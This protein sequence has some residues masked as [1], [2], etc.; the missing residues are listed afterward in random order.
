MKIDSGNT[1]N[2]GHAWL[3]ADAVMLQEV[4]LGGN[5]VTEGAIAKLRKELP[6]CD[7]Y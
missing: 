2:Q 3:L 4:E 1:I 5:H 7:I 6:R